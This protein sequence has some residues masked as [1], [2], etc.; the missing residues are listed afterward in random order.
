MTDESI[1]GHRDTPEGDRARWAEAFATQAREDW[2]LFNFLCDHGRTRCHQLQA[3][4][5]ACEKIAK[6]YRIR[7]TNAD[8]TVL[9]SGHVGFMRFI[10][11][12]MISPPIQRQYR[13]RGAQLKIRLREM[14]QIANE[15]ELLT[16]SIERDG[17]RDNCE[18]PWWDGADIAVPCEHTFPNLAVLSLQ[19]A[20]SHTFLK[21]MGRAMDEF[22]HIRIA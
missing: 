20:R 13:G 17:R 14:R 3:L 8:L 21:L 9:M 10:N 18:Y 1:P 19:G 5:M 6:A 2:R 12:F 16:P 15:I 7:D 11:A 22:E 4:Q